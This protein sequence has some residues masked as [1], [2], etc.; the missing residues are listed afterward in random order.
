MSDYS[1]SEIRR[2]R[3]QIVSE[4]HVY[5]KDSVL[6]PIVNAVIEEAAEVAYSAGMNGMH[7]DN[8][9]S[10]MIEEL[11]MFLQGVA[12]GRTSDSDNLG[13]YRKIYECIKRD[14]NPEYKEYLRLKVLFEN[15]DD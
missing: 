4:Y 13:A 11:K 8:G 15:N 2:F 12:Y 1:E 5:S 7:S 6:E 9:A 3:N 10:S 14:E